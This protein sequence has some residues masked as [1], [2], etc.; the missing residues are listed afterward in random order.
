MP[1]TVRLH[2]VLKAP[3]TGLS[4]VPRPHNVSGLRNGFTYGPPHGARK[5]GGTFKISFTTSH[6]AEPFLRRRYIELVAGRKLPF[7]TS[8][9]IEPARHLKVTRP[10]QR[11][12]PSAL[13][14]ITQ[15][16]IPTSSL[17]NV[18][19]R[20]AESLVLAMLVKPNIQR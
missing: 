17:S 16:N 12:C 15:E 8:S 4:R 5:V 9:T 11:S 7:T 1:G 19:S 10:P 14:N 3:P 13:V 6:H 20:L 2:R 18:L